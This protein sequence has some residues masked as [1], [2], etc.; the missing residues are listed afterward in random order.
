[1]VAYS[2]QTGDLARL[3]GIPAN[4]LHRKTSYHGKRVNQ[5][6]IRQLSPLSTVQLVGFA[7]CRE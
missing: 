2:K 5:R 1:M 6:V 4:P 7:L 3:E